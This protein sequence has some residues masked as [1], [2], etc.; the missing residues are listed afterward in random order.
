MFFTEEK[1]KELVLRYSNRV[2]F[3]FSY[4]KTVISDLLGQLVVLRMIGRH[5]YPSNLW[6]RQITEA[7][8]WLQA[9]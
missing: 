2:A 7:D 3:E 5:Y 6:K 4:V 9:P 1:K 8:I